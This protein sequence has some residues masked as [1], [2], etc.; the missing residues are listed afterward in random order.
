M[1][2]TFFR[3]NDVPVLSA[4][5][6]APSSRL[7]VPASDF[8]DLANHAFGFTVH[9][10]QSIVAER[11]I[12]S[13]TAVVPAPS[14]GTASMGV[15]A[16]STQWYFVD[17]ATSGNFVDT[18]FLLSNPQSTAAHVTLTYVLDGGATIGVSKIVPANGRLTTNVNSEADPRL[19]G[20]SFS[21][22]LISDIPIVAERSMSW[23]GESHTGPGAAEPGTKWILAEGRA[24][25]AQKFQTYLLLANPQNT[26]ASVS[27]TYLCEAGA[28][29]VQ[30][31]AVPAMSRLNIDV[32]A[33]PG[34][35]ESSFGMLV[36]AT[37]EVPIVVERSMY[38]S[39]NGV[40]FS[41]GTNVVGVRV[42]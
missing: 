13:G 35:Q 6:M 28:P 26:A 40:T 12:Y 11:S 7:T 4:L 1:T 10:T 36:E 30:T 18:F 33:I 32:N 25:G 23:L 27:V 9:A 16:P 41:G 31:Y 38:W 24:G 29:V 19:H 17:G 8:P 3:E 39:A 42:P 15:A 37:N 20:A 22:I 2:V 34:M 5:T 14:T 21:T